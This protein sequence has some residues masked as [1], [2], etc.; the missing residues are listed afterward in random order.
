MLKHIVQHLFQWFLMLILVRL[1][2]IVSNLESISSKPLEY[3]VYGGLMEEYPE[4]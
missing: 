1:V 4:G 2:K 3:T